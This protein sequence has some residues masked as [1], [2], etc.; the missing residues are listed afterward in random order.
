MKNIKA[1]LKLDFQLL[2]PYWK[3]WL[4]FLGISLF[5]GLV[6]Q[7]GYI[8][9]LSATIFAGTMMAFPFESTDNSN[10]NILYASL[11]TT[12]KSMVTARYMFI[13]LTLFA[14][15]AVS[16]VVGL[17]INLGFGNPITAGLIFPFITLSFALFLVS[18]GFQTPFMYKYGYVKGK[19]FMWIPI[20]LATI[21]L[22]LPAIF[23]LFRLDITF[24]IFEVLLRNP[25]VTSLISLGVGIAA[26]AMSF[27]LSRKTYLKK[28]I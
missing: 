6:N 23:N 20:V 26:I 10:L 13:L 22:M 11:P 4:L 14:A 3:W 16:T 17:I 1:L 28:D 15:L 9:M 25:T 2:V 8:F 18:V 21:V 5:I 12:R 7:D 24:N 19:I 27:F